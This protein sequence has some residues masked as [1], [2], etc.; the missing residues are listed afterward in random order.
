MLNLLDIRKNWAQIRIFLVGRPMSPDLIPRMFTNGHRLSITIFISNTPVVRV[1]KGDLYTL[2]GGFVVILL[3]AVITN[4]G[5]FSKVSSLSFHAST[6]V[7]QTTEIPSP[8]V[9]VVTTLPTQIPVVNLTPPA[10]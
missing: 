3:I 2:I 8:Q 6:P 1:D 5:A 9:T 10:P 4:P 7:V